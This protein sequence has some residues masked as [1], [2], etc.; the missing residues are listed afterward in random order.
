MRTIFWPR[1]N[2]GVQ[3][4]DKI[5]HANSQKDCVGMTSGVTAGGLYHPKNESA[6]GAEVGINTAREYANWGGEFVDDALQFG[7]QPIQVSD[8]RPRE[9]GGLPGG[10]CC[11]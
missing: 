11:V 5:H 10:I 9:T 7:E 6:V 8:D 2:K 3:Q 1:S 4:Y